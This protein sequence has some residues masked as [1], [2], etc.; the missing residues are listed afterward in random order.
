MLG[1]QELATENI[2]DEISLTSY[3]SLDNHLVDFILT[4]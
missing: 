4:L 2:K 1:Y 3:A